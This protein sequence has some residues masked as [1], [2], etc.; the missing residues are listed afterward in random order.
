MRAVVLAA[1]KGTRMKEI[2][3]S[4]PKPMV[5]VGGRPI[6]W[7]LLRSLAS[8]G[9][10]EAAIIVGYMGERVRDYFGD[11]AEVGVSL[12]YFVQEVQDGTGRAAEPARGFLDGA[13][14]FFTFGDILATTRAYAEMVEEFRRTP[15]DL[16]MAVRSVERPENYGILE[17]E[18]DRVVRIVE[19]PEPGT[20]ESNLANGGIFIADPVI[21]DYTA[22][23][24]LSERGEYELTDAIRMM[25][26]EERVVRVLR[27][28]Y[29]RDVGTPEDLEAAA[30]EIG[31]GGVLG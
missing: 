4:T 30:H 8:A 15:A 25:I 12:T 16:L 17:T 23:L 27:L 7:H 14:F 13:P 24:E 1:G 2:T 10:T 9:V 21:F 5:E 31:E 18:G 3:D 11:G 20:T 19:K 6:L 26:D 28:D 22:R 29:W